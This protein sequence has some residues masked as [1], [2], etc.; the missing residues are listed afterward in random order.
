MLNPIL[1][2]AAG[3]PL[4]L[5]APAALGGERALV[6]GIMDYQDPNIRPPLYG[7]EGDAKAFE[8]L[9]VD[10]LHFDPEKIER[11]TNSQATRQGILD[12]LQRLV[13]KT[14]QGDRVVLYYSG[15][16]D[17]I[18]DQPPGDPRHDESDGKDEVLVAYDAQVNNPK[19]YV[20]D[21]EVN[22]ALRQLQGRKVLAVIDSCHS[23]TVTRGASGD[24]LAGVKTPHFGNPGLSRGP[25]ELDKQTQV[26]GNFIQRSGEAGEDWVAFFA[27]SPNQLALETPERDKIHYHGVFTKAFIDGVN[28]EA[29]ENRD[30][31]VAY[32]ELL[33]YTQKA[34]AKYCAANPK[35]CETG[36]GLTPDHDYPDSKAGEDILGFG[37][38]QQAQPTPAEWAANTLVHTGQATIKLAM[39]PGPGVAPKTLLGYTVESDRPGKLVLLDI[40]PQG[41]LRQLYPNPYMAEDGHHWERIY[42]NQPLTLPGHLNFT[43]KAGQAPGQ[44]LL[45]AVLIEDEID[46]RDLIKLQ[47]QGLRLIGNPAQWLGQL[48]GKLDGL[49]HQADGRNRA[50]EWSMAS[51]P[52]TVTSP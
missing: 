1:A 9:L 34:S 36:G 17:W 7:P 39:Q 24:D 25:D 49:F 41:Q 13:E 37:A 19:T 46:T 6:I 27:V 47:G 29:D 23:G 42:A 12:A 45:V 15:H 31:R 8:K 50:I 30:R 38:P 3:L 21:D 16:G 18:D 5:A 51:L 10:K 28:G 14:G 11:L 52:Y 32:H 22:A 48:S 40:D 2:L 44:G 26:E 20:L 35:K 43:L 4:L 33:N